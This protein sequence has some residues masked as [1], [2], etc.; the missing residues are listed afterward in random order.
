MLTVA[1]LYGITLVI[2][3]TF[4][5]TGIYLI[6]IVKVWNK[7]DYWSFDGET[8]IRGKRP[9]TTISMSEIKSIRFGLPKLS[10]WSERIRRFD[11]SNNYSRRQNRAQEAVLIYLDKNR[12]VPVGVEYFSN[13]DVFTIYLFYPS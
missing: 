6:S 1:N 7:Y 10:G 12:V 13:G 5:C 4:L 8:L 2:L 11:S 3:F 9:N